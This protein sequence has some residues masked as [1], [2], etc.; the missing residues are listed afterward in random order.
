MIAIFTISLQEHLCWK[1]DYLPFFFF[2]L[3]AFFDKIQFL[4]KT[5]DKLWVFRLEYLVTF[6]YEESELGVSGQSTDNI[7]SCQ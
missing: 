1:P 3:L 6:P 4:L 2:L 5:T 7:Y